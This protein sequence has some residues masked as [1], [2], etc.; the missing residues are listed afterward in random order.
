VFGIS[1]F[2]NSPFASLAGAVYNS[3]VSETGTATDAISSKQTFISAVTETGTATDVVSSSQTFVSFIVETGTATDAAFGRVVYLSA[4][5]E[6]GTATDSTV[7]FILF[8][9]SIAETGT[10]TDVI[11]STQTFNSLIAEL[12][13]ATDSVSMRLLWELI[14]DSQTANWVVINASNATSWGTIDT[15]VIKV[16]SADTILNT[17]TTDAA[18]V[19]ILSPYIVTLTSGHTWTIAEQQNATWT[20][21]GTIN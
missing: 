11:G 6:T 20:V 4:V 3:A 21:I 2:A 15:R 14:D 18:I 19:E 7:G 5:T 8:S 16:Y 9:T 1:T 10:A 13:T 12:A 17:N